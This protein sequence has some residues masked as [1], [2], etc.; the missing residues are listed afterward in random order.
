MPEI[1]A[2]SEEEMD[3]IADQL[4]G[5]VQI[6]SKK[7]NLGAFFDATEKEFRRVL[8]CRYLRYSSPHSSPLSLPIA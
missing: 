5:S 6:V 2:I 1:E 7:G 3:C 8:V 4:M